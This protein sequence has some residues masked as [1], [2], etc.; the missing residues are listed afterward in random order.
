MTK[1]ILI[2]GDDKV[3]KLALECGMG[4]SVIKSESVPSQAASINSRKRVVHFPSYKVG[5]LQYG[6]R[7]PGRNDP[8][9]C[10]SGKKYKRCCLDK[11]YSPLRETVV[12]VSRHNG[13]Q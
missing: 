12:K 9:H 13:G 3:M 8:C 4:D 2:T 10:G 7:V 6:K 5:T 1:K 11:D